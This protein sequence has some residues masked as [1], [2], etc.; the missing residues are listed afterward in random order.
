MNADD[1]KNFG[2][3]MQDTAVPLVARKKNEE[4]EY[5]MLSKDVW[6]QVRKTN[7]GVL[8]YKTSF[9]E[10][11]FKSINLN[12]NTRK[13]IPLPEQLPAL[14]NGSKSISTQKYKDLLQLLKGLPC[15]LQEP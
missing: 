11:T 8:C 10:E 1:F 7:P 3:L 14:A 12:R 2:T 15:L 13:R 9:Y 4:G 5:F 6:L